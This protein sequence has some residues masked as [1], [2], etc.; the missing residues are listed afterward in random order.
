M[1]KKDQ[2]TPCDQSF[3]MRSAH[4]FILRVRRSAWEAREVSRG[5]TES[6]RADSSLGSGE[7]DAFPA[8]SGCA[9][10]PGSTA[11]SDMSEMRLSEGG[12]AW[13]DLR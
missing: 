7:W 11:G 12:S 4:L 8:V 2:S 9:R 6:R 3:R 1:G 13:K 10:V 5:G